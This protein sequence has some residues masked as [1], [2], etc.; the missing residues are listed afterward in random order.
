M[1]VSAAQVETVVKQEFPQGIEGM[2]PSV[3]FVAVHKRLR[4]QNPTDKLR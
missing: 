4:S 3:V 1:V 2:D